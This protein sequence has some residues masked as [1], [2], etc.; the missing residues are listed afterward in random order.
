MGSSTTT[1]VSM[2]QEEQENYLDKEVQK[3]A[4]DALGG[5]TPMWEGVQIFINWLRNFLKPC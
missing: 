3:Q 1:V 5:D 4:R 2:T